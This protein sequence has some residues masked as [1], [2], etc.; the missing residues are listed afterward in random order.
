MT[1][2]KA[3]GSFDLFTKW[4]DQAFQISPADASEIISK[5]LQRGLDEVSRDSDLHINGDIQARENGVLILSQNA[6]I[7]LQI[8]QKLRLSR[9]PSSTIMR[10]APWGFTT[11]Q[12]EEAVR[13]AAYAQP[14]NYTGVADA[15][16]V[17]STRI[18]SRY[19]SIT[20]GTLPLKA[21]RIDLDRD[22]YEP[23]V[24]FSAQ[25]TPV[26]VQEKDK[27]IALGDMGGFLDWTKMI[28][29]CLPLKKGVPTNLSNEVI[30]T[31]KEGYERTNYVL[32]PEKETP[33]GTDGTY[34]VSAFPDLLLRLIIWVQSALAHK[35]LAFVCWI[36]NFDTPQ[37]NL[38]QQ[39]SGEDFLK[40]YGLQR[41]QTNG[42]IWVTQSFVQQVRR[43]ELLNLVKPLNAN[44]KEL[45]VIR[46]SEYPFRIIPKVP[47]SKK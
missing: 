8:V 12:P 31:L 39:P 35:G 5:A 43:P 38:A 28:A 36:L 20:D 47:A 21:S 32:C 17:V 27:A 34:I 40:S 18:T 26:T 15:T 46:W 19:A 4:L 33:S 10:F 7:L 25:L 29:E 22:A 16:F 2:Y 11:E 37:Y 41:K 3:F 1:T 23:S 9:T 6:E 14:P 24:S 44:G 13:L 42:D 30:S 45:Y